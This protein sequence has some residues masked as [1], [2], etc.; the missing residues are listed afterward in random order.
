[1]RMRHLAIAALLTAAAC[2]G[3]SGPATTPPSPS[4]E[5]EQE[6]EPEAPP[7]GLELSENEILGKLLAVAWEDEEAQLCVVH[8]RGRAAVT[9]P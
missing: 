9:R 4:P 6:A 2:G 7:A 1:M 3:R 5:A 8:A